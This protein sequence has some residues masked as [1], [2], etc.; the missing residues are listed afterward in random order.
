M[1]TNQVDW[2]LYAETRLLGRN[3]L[4]FEHH[5]EVLRDFLNY[6][7]KLS[8]DLHIFDIGCSSGFFL[9]I[10]RELGFDK[11]EG[12]D[13]SAKFVSSART[14]GLQCRIADVINGFIPEETENI[15]DVVLLMDILEHLPEPVKALENCKKIL[16]IDG[17][18][19]ITVPIYDSLPER[20]TRT[21]RKKTRLQ[22][23]KEHDHTHIQAFSETDFYKLLKE[24]DLIIVESKRL[25]CPIPRVSKRKI[26]DLINLLL[27][28]FWKGEFLRV[29]VR[30]QNPVTE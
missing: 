1:T 8:I 16:K 9:V 21:I 17:I 22:Q 26:R 7:S 20:L 14:K 10:L 29:V 5:Q 12:I 25:Y 13:I 2:E 23:A 3:R 28:N 30:V 4:L 19:Y 6:F 11:I 27:P 15:A 18:I 24:A